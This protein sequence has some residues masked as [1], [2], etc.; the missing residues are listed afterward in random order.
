[1]FKE[2]KILLECIHLF[3]YQIILYS[4]NFITLVSFINQ[5][6]WV[7]MNI[8]FRYAIHWLNHNSTIYNG[9]VFKMGVNLMDMFLWNLLIY[10]PIADNDSKI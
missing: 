7:I 9:S 8:V 5:F 2:K 1:M 3:G 6:V 4:D 10:R